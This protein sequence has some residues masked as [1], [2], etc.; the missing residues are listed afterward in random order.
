MEAKAS[1]GK[2]LSTCIKGLQFSSIFFIT[3]SP[4]IQYNS[5]PLLSQLLST[6]LT[7]QAFNSNTTTGDV[8]KWTSEDPRTSTLFN[9]YGI[10]Y[11]FQVSLD[12]CIYATPPPLIISPIDR[13]NP[14]QACH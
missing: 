10:M 12:R 6:R 14:R 7:M 1:G 3:S 8:L 2:A 4:L 13:R 11:R 9:P 5:S